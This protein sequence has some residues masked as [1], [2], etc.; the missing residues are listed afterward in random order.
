M[1]QAKPGG[2]LQ[3]LILTCQYTWAM[4][5][6]PNRSAQKVSLL[7][8]YSLWDAMFEVIKD[9]AVQPC[10]DCFYLGNFTFLC[11]IMKCPKL[12]SHV[13]TPYNYD[14]GKNKM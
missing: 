12:G 5:G 2:T 3:I 6:L 14:P 11:H 10:Y 8:N 1:I 13:S 4:F 7:N 9:A